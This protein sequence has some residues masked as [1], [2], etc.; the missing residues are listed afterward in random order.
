[1]SGTGTTLE[2]NVARWTAF[3]RSQGWDYPNGAFNAC[4]V[5]SR[6]FVPG[7]TIANQL[8]LQEMDL[9]VRLVQGLHPEFLEHDTGLW[10]NHAAVGHAF[11]V[12]DNMAIDFTFRQFD[13]NAEYPHVEPLE[14]YLVRWNTQL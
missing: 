9:E 5:A 4:Q 11:V 12:A 3:G 2:N 6:N 13:A 10:P 14:D 7:T 8:G 1:M